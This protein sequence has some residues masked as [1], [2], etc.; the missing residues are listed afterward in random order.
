MLQIS[1]WVCWGLFLIFDVFLSQLVKSKF[2][3]N[4]QTHSKFSVTKRKCA[5]RFS[6]LRFLQD[7][8]LVFRIFVPL[9]QRSW[10]ERPWKVPKKSDFRLNWA[11]LALKCM[12]NKFLGVLPPAIVYCQSNQNRF[13][14]VTFESRSFRQASSIRNQDSRYEVGKMW[15][16]INAIILIVNWA[17][18][19][20]CHRKRGNKVKTFFFQAAR[21][22][23]WG[24]M[25]FLKNV[26]RILE[27]FF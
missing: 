25:Y 10:N 5:V 18:C 11:Y 13:C 2:A 20:Q 14:N 3:T 8:T 26:T 6:G 15:V 24:F 23:V 21:T 22:L 17:T 27:F 12:N 1:C 7:V 9:D 19:L 4:R 16:L